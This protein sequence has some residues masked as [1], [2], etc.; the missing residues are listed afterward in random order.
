MLEQ[1]A[2]HVRAD[3]KRGVG[4]E[5]CALEG[6][7]ATHSFDEADV[8]FAQARLT[9]EIR[10]APDVTVTPAKTTGGNEQKVQRVVY[11][12]GKTRSRTRH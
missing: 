11:S 7:E 10:T 1:V 6:I 3:P 2:E 12:S 9:E 8:P 4:G 5:L